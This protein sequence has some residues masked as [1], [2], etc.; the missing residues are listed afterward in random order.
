[1]EK[2]SNFAEW[3]VEAIDNA[4]IVDRRYP[5]KG[6]NVWMPYGLRA[7]RL[8]NGFMHDEMARTGH[9]EV[10]FPV[11]VPEDQFQKEADHIKGFGANVYW[12]THGGLNELDVRLLLRPTSEAAMYS[13]YSLWIRAH[14]DLPLKLYQIVPVFRYETKQTRTFIR[15]RELS[16][17]FESHTAHVSFEDAEAQIREDLE[18]WARIGRKYALPALFNRRPDWDKFAGAHYSVGIDSYVSAP[19]RAMQVASIHQY[20]DNFARVYDVTFEDERGERQYAHQTTY[21]ISERILGAV[22]A[23]HGD[24]RGV[25]F[26]PEIAPIQVVIVPILAKGSRR[27]L[28]R[29]AESLQD[30][31]SAAARS[32]LDVRD[33][34]PGAKFYEWERKGVPLRVEMGL[35]ELEG[36]YV[37]LVRRDTGTRSKAKRGDAV[38]RI[39]SLLTRIQRDLF[40]KAERELQEGIH[41]ID[42]Y[43]DVPSGGIIRTGWC[44]KE[45]CGLAMEEKLGR[46]LLGTPYEPE[47]FRGH[48]LEC[49]EEAEAVAYVAHSY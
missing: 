21:G 5:I 41:T 16:F 33:M 37:T 48:C 17:F 38:K 43:E 35:E 44:G 6:M 20:R 29:A 15:V 28:T 40:Q 11:L 42:T 14:T 9:E 7:M 13:L 2:K 31:I 26:P 1:M 46:P 10:Q 4:Q 39:R 23:I 36:A 34:R 18:I 24:D 32:E 25:V 30:E 19:G 3:Y 47:E 27:K 45:S 12:V 8:V 22:V 49:G